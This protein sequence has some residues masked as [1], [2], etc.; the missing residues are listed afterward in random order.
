MSNRMLEAYNDS[1]YGSNGPTESFAAKAGA[2]AEYLP[3]FL[4][5]IRELG[6]VLQVEQPYFQQAWQAVG[7][8][9]AE[10]YILGAGEWGLGRWERLLHLEAPESLSLDERRQALLLRLNEQLPFTVTRLREL[11]AAAAPAGQYTMVLDEKNYVLHVYI[12]L[13]AK[14]CL[15]ALRALLQ[16]VAPANLS[17]HLQLMFN[18]HGKLAK[19]THQQLSQW[20]CWAIREEVLD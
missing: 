11:L 17:L 5:N 18:T 3:D 2:L 15:P 4:V 10:Q 19:F 20:S 7:Q 8:A 14:G 12:T 6:Q 16:R 13:A 9:L 1:E